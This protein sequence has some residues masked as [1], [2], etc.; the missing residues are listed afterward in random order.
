MS[1][2]K[3]CLLDSNIWLYAFMEGQDAEKSKAAKSVIQNQE[4]SI[5]TSTQI[6]NEV[7]VNLVRKAHFPEEKIQ[8][9]IESF[10]NK[11]FVVG[12]DK[13]I[14]VSASKIRSQHSFSYWDSLVF[15]SA[16]SIG[17]EVLYS[18]DMQDGF[19]I[20][21]TRIVNPFR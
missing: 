15:T 11:Y 1:N 13:E 20:E 6:I 10:H 8:K 7:C 3:I 17:A 18:E 14:L 12:M 5:A 2:K 19:I 4:T 16:L 9:L 21:N